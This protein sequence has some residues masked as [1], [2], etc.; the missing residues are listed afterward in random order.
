MLSLVALCPAAWASGHGKSVFHAVVAQDGSGDFTTVQAA[1][2]AAPEGRTTPWRIFIKRGTYREHVTIPE[3][4]RYISLVG[5]GRGNTAISYERVSGGG[6]VVSVDDGATLT[7]YA[8]DLYFEGIDFVNSYGQEHQDG[9][10]ATAL[11]TSNDRVVLNRCGII[12]FQDTWLTSFYHPNRRHYAVNCLI[13]G[14]VDFIYGQGNVF[15]DSDTLY[16]MRKESGY[17]VAPNHDPET[18][19][20]YVFRNSV[21]TAPGDPIETWTYLGRPWHSSPKVAFIN[22]KSY[23]TLPPEGWYHHMGGL[24]AV[25]AEYNT[26]DS[27]GRPLDLSRRCSRYWIEDSKGDTAWCTSKAVITADEAALYTVDNVLSGTDGWQPRSIAKPCKASVVGTAGGYITWQP[28]RGAVGYIVVN[29][30]RVVGFTTE[31]RYKRSKRAEYEVRSVSPWVA[32]SV[33]GQDA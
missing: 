24:P 25:F 6:K 18:R 10:Q 22:T 14:A 19:W 16:I 2:G 8:T 32:L 5:E 31:C 20:G 9:P 21:I 4:K 30:G 7:A 13:Q 1:I 15:F 28:V 33:D 29:D 3:K 11:Y 17:I 27:Q 23:V 26:V 12:S